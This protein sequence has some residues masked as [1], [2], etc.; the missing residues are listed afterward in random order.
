MEIFIG[1]DQSING[2]GITIKK[3][4]KENSEDLFYLIVGKKKLSGREKKAQDTYKNFDYI[5][6]PKYE[7]KD[8]KDSF[9]LEMFK[10]KNVIN[11]SEIIIKLVKEFL[12]R[13]EKEITALYVCMEGVSFNS[14]NTRSIVELSALN[15]LIRY[16]LLKLF[17][18]YNHI[19][20]GVI[21]GAPKQ[22]KKF[23]TGDGNAKKDSMI[24]LFEALYPNFY[25]IPKIDDIADSYWMCNFVKNIYETELKNGKVC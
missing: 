9:E 19:K 12:L 23:A 4:F 7:A 5:L 13:Y 6:Y 17:K 2:T 24:C 14:G 11:I 1:I 10:T 15:Y 25:L 3:N 16:R 8:A 20:T 22:I 21:I 18:E